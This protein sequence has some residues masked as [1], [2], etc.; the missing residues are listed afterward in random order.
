[1]TAASGLVA[2]GISARLGERTVLRDVDLAAAPGQCLVI[3]GP[4]GAGKTSLLKCLAGLL[5]PAAGTVAVDGRDLLSAGERERARWVGY[6]PQETQ[7]GFPFTALD[8][9]LMGRHPHLGWLDA[10]SPRDVEIARQALEACDAAALAD[11]PVTRISGGERR[12]VFFARTLAQRT[13]IL[14]LDEPTADQDL[15]HALR[16]LEC[17]RRDADTCVVAVLHDLN[18]AGRFADRLLLLDDGKVVAQGEPAEILDPGVLNPVYRVAVTV[19]THGKHRI[20]FPD[21]L[22]DSRA[23]D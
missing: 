23:R 18:L 13:R 6:L 20:V 16:L 9:V 4:N 5:K 10:E 1:M 11:R 19:V 3:I 12:R 14:L 22:P 2:S 21:R 7:V 8:V 15:H 17:A